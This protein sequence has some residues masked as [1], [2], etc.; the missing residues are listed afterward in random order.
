MKEMASRV[1]G[2]KITF[3]DAGEVLLLISGLALLVWCAGSERET[4][5]I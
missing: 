1:P 2:K 4:T 5:R 3:V